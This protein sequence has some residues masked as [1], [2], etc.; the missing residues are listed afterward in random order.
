MAR[1]RAAAEVG[2]DTFLCVPGS[3]E[4]GRYLRELAAADAGVLLGIEVGSFDQL[5]LRIAG[6]P[7]VRRTDRAMERIIVREA[8]QD[9]PAFSRS[10]K[11]AGFAD[12]ALVHVDRLRRAR[13]WGGAQLD[14]AISALP[15]GGTAAWFALE[16]R[17][18]ELLDQ[19]RLR[20]DA[21]IEAR[22]V[23]AMRQGRTGL[24]CVVVHGFEAFS[25]ARV[26]LLERLAAVIPVMVTLPWRPGRTIHERDSASGRDRVYERASDLRDRWRGAFVEEL[27]EPGT[28][29]PE[30]VRI[31][32]ELFERTTQSP[33]VGPRHVARAGGAG[34]APV[35]FVDCC[36]SLQEAE[37]VVR[38]VAALAASGLTWDDIAV[39]SA[40]A[41][42]DA[43]LL[44]ASFERAGIPA[45]L[46]ARRT[47]PEVPAG[48]AV[49][50]LLSA[51]VEDDPLRLV[52]ALRARAFGM[53]RT[54]I[55]AAE[56]Q[57]R[58]YR[59]AARTMLDQGEVARLLPAEVSALLDARRATTGGTLALVRGLLTSMLPHGR[60]DLEL[61]R[62]L[63]AMLDGLTL[64]AGDSHEV[65]LPEVVEAIAGFPLAVPDRSDAGAVVVAEIEDLRSVTFGGLVLRGLHLA[66]FRVPVED[67]AEGP[68]AARDLLHL[69]VTS[70]RDAL[71]VVRQVSG[72]DGGALAASPAWI[73]LRR[74]APDA[75]LRERRLGTVVVE[76]A[77][78]RLACEV[79]GSVGFA[80]G[81][82]TLV[83][84]VPAAT[85]DLLAR[86]RRT[87]RPATVGGRAGAELAALE[88]ISVTAVEK[89]ASCPAK[90]FVEH[91][92]KA[93]D[94]DDDL[95]NLVAGSLAHAVLQEL[96][97]DARLQH[98]GP[99]EVEARAASIAPELAR[100][101]DPKRVLDTARIERIARQAAAVLVAEAA[102][103]AP[104]AIEVERSFGG[105]EDAIAPGLVV[106][107]VEV[108]GRIDRVDRWGS[109]V[110]LHDYKYGSTVGSGDR[111]VE[112]GRLQLLVYMLALYA[113]GS[114]YEPLGG[115]YRAVTAEPAGKPW[116]TMR[117]E[118]VDH[119]IITKRQKAGVVDGDGLEQR[120]DE[121]KVVVEAA[122]DGIRA[123]RVEPLTSPSA[124]PSH[125]HLQTICRVGEVA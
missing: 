5:L 46:Q 51:I 32:A 65:T 116:G 108:V 113:P 4:R 87:A 8:L 81:Q 49:H 112:S 62:G 120:L 43:D 24:D 39:A 38:E 99:E 66:G 73:E 11:W 69:A 22:A 53:E 20:D 19:R 17:V 70:V 48:R 117:T 105:D 14:T 12:T 67:E 75:P 124:C 47:A 106:H 33:L 100:K 118:L 45:R 103:D 10:A 30:L 107:G 3:V 26:E 58:G 89:Y 88:T 15:G 63:A 29:D 57:L 9:V 104:D 6:S 115:I 121:A 31:A 34:L 114:P 2:E 95:S 55:D 76:P 74:L 21:W 23:R 79:P 94:P 60:G 16:R 28:G 7:P 61:L 85:A 41:S 119:G 97:R 93:R 27:H 37:E 82:G 84:G 83:R 68:T 125:C 110:L 50:E 71:R 44:L 78:V 52:A 42:T 80:T 123:G 54:R 91:R 109:Q 86:M 64:A 36:G 25:P 102:W 96:A 111:L 122:V 90:W 35:A 101:V 13:V 77:E 92:L 72:A 40:H 59:H 56:L 98:L 1:I 18:G